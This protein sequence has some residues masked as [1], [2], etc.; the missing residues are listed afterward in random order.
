MTADY[1]IDVVI[2][3]FNGASTI[4]S[5]IESIQRQTFTAMPGYYRMSPKVS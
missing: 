4:R 5:A 3:V 1:F 2:P